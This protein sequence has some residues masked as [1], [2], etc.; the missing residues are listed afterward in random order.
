[1][2]ETMGYIS[3]HGKYMEKLYLSLSD[4]TG[5]EQTEKLINCVADSCQNLKQI[6]LR[7]YS[8]CLHLITVIKTL[9]SSLEKLK[10]I[11]EYEKAALTFSTV[12]LILK[13]CPRLKSLKASGIHKID[14]HNFEELLKRFLRM[15]HLDR[16]KF[17][18]V[19]Y[20]ESEF[21]YCNGRYCLTKFM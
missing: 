6:V 7:I 18:S 1:M 20:P 5:E 14:R 4:Y 12:A 16:V 19:H 9:G 8:D 3:L 2:N 15:P 10:L 21:I 11:F 17:E 13:H